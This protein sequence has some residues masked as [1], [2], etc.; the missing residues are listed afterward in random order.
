MKQFILFIALT[1]C[2]LNGTAAWAQADNAAIDQQATQLEAELGKFKETSPEAAAIML[3]LVDLYHGNAR[4][5]GLAR[6]ARKFISAHPDNP[7]HKDVMLKLI[8]S[9]EILARDE[10]LT[11][12]CRQFIQ[13]YP[14]DPAYFDIGN[15]LAAALIRDNKIQDGA[16]ILKSLWDKR[17]NDQG[18]YDGANAISWYSRVNNGESWRNS[19]V[20]GEDMYAKVSDR[21][22]KQWLGWFAWYSYMR[23]GDT[24]NGAR[25]AKQLLDEG[26]ATTPGVRYQLLRVLAQYSGNHTTGADYCRQALALRYTTDVHEW[27]L[28]RL[29]NA[30]S[31]GPE[32]EQEF[33]RYAQKYPNTPMRWARQV[34]V[35]DAYRDVD[36]NYDRAR[37][38]LAEVIQH[39]PYAQ[40]RAAAQYVQ[41]IDTIAPAAPETPTEDAAELQ[42]RKE[43]NDK[44]QPLLAQAE[45]F[46]AQTLGQKP[47]DDWYIRYVMAME[48][49]STRLKQPPRARQLLH[50]LLNNP[51]LSPEA[52]NE[53]WYAINY[54]LGDNANDGEFRASADLL[55]ES[56]RRSIHSQYYRDL[57]PRWAKDTNTRANSAEQVLADQLRARAKYVTDKLAQ[58]DADPVAALWL[59]TNNNIYDQASA[60]SLGALYEPALRGKH[61]P[62]QLEYLQSV[63]AA[64]CYSA[65]PTPEIRQRAHE[66][67]TELNNRFPAN[68]TYLRQLLPSLGYVPITPEERTEKAQP[69]IEKILAQPSWHDPYMWLDMMRSAKDDPALKRRIAEWIK[70]G[71][72]REQ[73]S[74][75][76]YT[77]VCNFFWDQGMKPDAVDLARWIVEWFPESADAASLA[78]DLARW[79]QTPQQGEAFLQQHINA[80]P[81]GFAPPLS[82]V[83]YAY[84]DKDDVEGALR[85]TQLLGQQMQEWPF[86]FWQIPVD[87]NQFQLYLFY[88]P[89]KP[90]RF[91]EKDR[92]R[93]WEIVAIWQ[94]GIG[95][96][97]AV[98]QTL[99][100]MDRYRLA[101]NQD[102]TLPDSQQSLAANMPATL[103]QRATAMNSLERFMLYRRATEWNR[104]D[105]GQWDRGMRYAQEAIG[106]K[107]YMEAAVLLTGM[108]SYTQNIDEARLKNGRN[109]VG[110]CYSRVGAVGL[111]ID[112]SSPFAS[113]MQAALYLRLGDERLAMDAYLANA[114]LFDQHRDELPADLVLFVCRQLI[115]AGTQ[116]NHD[117]VEEILRGWMVKNS[118][119]TQLTDSEKA[120]FQL[121]LAQNYF[122]AQ[123]YDVARAE[124][125]TL[126]NRYPETSQAVEAEFGIGETYMAQKVYDQAELVFEKLANSQ[127]LNIVVRAEFLRGVLAFRRGDHDDARKIFS[128]VLERVPDIDL[129]NQTLFNLAEIFGAEERYLDQLNLLRTVGRLGRAS[130]RRHEPGMALSIV[131]HDSDLGLSRG[132][133]RIEVIV[134]TEPGGD[135]ETVYLTSGGASKGLFRVD[136]DTRLGSA[137]P[138]D[139]VLQLTGRDVIHCDYPES[140]KKEF[141]NVPLSDVEIQIA[142]DADFA[143]AS[144]KI[145]DEK[146]ESF[147]ERLEREARE[148]EEADQ[149]VSQGRPKSEIKPGNPIYLRVKDSD[150]DLGDE[151]DKITVKVVADSG[152]QVQAVLQETGPHTGLFE[153]TIG[154]GELPA[155]ALASDNSIGHTPLM[156]IDKDPQT[157]WLSEP[158]GET[159]KSLTIDLKDLKTV[160]RVKLASPNPLQNTPLGLDLLGSQDGE[161]WFKIVG[162][163]QPVA[164]P[165]VAGEFGHIQQRV[166][167]GN[168]TGF[169]LWQQ[170]VDLTKNAQPV[171]Q[172][173]IDQLNW[174]KP[175][176]AAEAANPYA[177]VWHG[178][179]PQLRT[180][181]IRL[182]VKGQV[183][184]I[185]V[186]GILELP[187]GAGGRSV[188]IWLE[189]GL[190]DLTI[191]SAVTAASQGVEATMT[192]ADFS[193]TEFAL[194]QF[195]AEDLDLSKTP[196]A[197]YKPADASGIELTADTAEIHKKTE[198]FAVR[199]QNEGKP[200]TGDWLTL[201][202]WLDWDVE[203]QIPGIYQISV[204]QS[205][206]GEVGKYRIELGNHVLEANVVNTGNW[207]VVRNVT[208]GSV[209]VEKP[210]KIKLA[211]KPLEIETRLLD[212]RG[213]SIRKMESAAMRSGPNWD[214]RFKP[215]DLRFVRV[216]VNEYSG[217]AVA[218]SNV[219]V[220]DVAKNVTHIPTEA[221]ILELA[222][223]DVL[224]IAGGDVV[225]ASYTDEFTQNAQGASRLLSSELT[226]T[227]FNATVS[228]I[229]Y[230]FTRTAGGAV[231]TTPKRLLRVEPG[232]RIIFQITDYDQDRTA[233]RDTIEFQVVVNDAEPINLTATETDEYSGIFTKELDTAAVD[234]DGKITVK[235]GDRI[236]GIYSD[237]QNTFPG[238][239][240]PRET[241]VYVNEPTDGLVRVLESHATWPEVAAGTQPGEKKQGL[242]RRG[243]PQ[244]TYATPKESDEI[245]GVAFEAPLTVEV[246][247]P[248]AA[249]DSR[250]SVIVKLTTGEGTEL[251]VE[252]VVSNSFDQD[253]DNLD[254]DYALRRGRFVGQVI[255]QLGGKES[256]NVIPLTAE[257]P[258]GLIGGPARDEAESFNNLT[259]KVINVSGKDVISAVYNDERRPEGKPEKLTARGRLLVDG[260]LEITNRE[261][262]EPIEQ[263]HVGE[264]LFLRID[265][266]DRDTSDDRDIVQVK[267]TTEHGDAETV[268]LAET[269]AHSGVFTASLQLKAAEKPTPKNINPA[270]PM[271]ETYFGDRIKA[272]YVD[273]SASSKAGDLELSREVPVVIGT[274]GL[275]AAFTK[276]FNNE[277]LAIETKFHIAES[278]FELFKSH[279]ELGRDAEQTGDLEAGRRVL[280]EVMED[281]P[282]PKYAPRIA[283]L[284]GQFAQELGQ[285]EEAIASYDLIIR[286]YPDHSLAPDAQYKMAQCYEEAGDFDQ[287]LE[288]Y[289]TLAATYPKSPL[290]ASCMIRIS[291]Y[292]YQKQEFKIASQVGTKFLE[293]FPG[294]EHGARMAFRV[295]QSYYKAKEYVEGGKAFDDF[296]KRFPDDKLAADALF[297]S[298][299][300][301]RQAND[302]QQ[303]FRRYNRCRW[304]FPASEAAKYARGRLALPEMIA[305]FEQEAAAL[306]Q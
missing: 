33:Q 193:A 54:L 2:G 229:A 36:L 92:L 81:L 111:T 132:H 152:D 18:Y 78:G 185:V 155:G 34:L 14:N 293:K 156:A 273:P 262:D 118:E 181:A 161:F 101:Q 48:L 86:L 13:K 213:I 1:I 240:V 285:W 11:A 35:A 212:L 87:V 153:A 183:I 144:S 274:D 287:A 27:L 282:D 261:Y 221:D 57:L 146:E 42:R 210:G 149:R 112:E 143:V 109:L 68:Q 254:P 76:Y 129:A 200:I 45:Q 103:V 135:R 263:L 142:A 244:I 47:A 20:I 206:V 237:V 243:Q 73:S 253:A 63:Y 163:P 198:T 217:E 289:V 201:D 214:L 52:Q 26:M 113:L 276:V 175:A 139:H 70:K 115:A 226:A 7:R 44:R 141:H 89:Q 126:I 107:Q 97:D 224:E 197:D 264:K 119:S 301:F 305:Q 286:Q 255:M 203:L 267:I 218:I 160:S 38:L 94:N 180:G 278:Y 299:E 275:V 182:G 23:A 59:Q 246:I 82:V 173:E 162:S 247:D 84:R 269:L 69:I 223:N 134:T 272:V 147:A 131:V 121:L 91:A 98:L 233:E 120:A 51:A 268:E 189:K 288:G 300:S 99:R 215:F 172:A 280:R 284:L 166:Y 270:E 241:V 225:T 31:K 258:R 169:T 236:Y 154:T 178:K 208:V 220:I 50:E 231:N 67:Y 283:Y 124:F 29:R 114:A 148:E 6:T 235:P 295:G 12:V 28:D 21:R 250:S 117:H 55:V 41:L 93:L 122:K 71:V 32:L 100:A 96:S 108:L 302:N 60:K 95:S 194:R 110:L 128:S 207:D 65:G 164:V 266:P 252:C 64:H 43:M 79:D 296:V 227:Y 106:R 138:G 105:G 104:F 211:M 167:S 140:F 157:F 281:Y 127:E 238:H 123:R 292:F 116:E 58:T 297:W 10:D 234:A 46:L 4:V 192:R 170:I 228:S 294:H 25:F 279:R 56:R 298:G 187:V 16:A 136:L 290:I 249:K 177:V 150:R 222:N 191:F 196:T 24:T 219:E 22:R 3:Q 171:E 239:A 8:D 49:Y 265:D 230:D 245:T 251:D 133:S 259:A 242:S 304:D 37:A 176:D 186:D 66:I 62:D 216:A 130:K 85:V 184:A 88:D 271:I 77:F 303:A 53:Q 277:S 159:P 165:P 248:D 15:R 188:D 179:L 39:Q 232:E 74:I 202:D 90:G 195:R 204:E 205:H 9:L 17:P 209:F 168:Y 80:R 5:L 291:D 30:G 125:T 257:M 72:D 256:P 190:H 61:S 75:V 260:A 19:A 306:D 199:G 174:S 83:A 40:R 137:T 145:I 151:A 158:D 102:A